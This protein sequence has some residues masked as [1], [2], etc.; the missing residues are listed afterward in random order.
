MGDDTMVK[1]RAQDKT[2]QWRAAGMMRSSPVAGNAMT[3]RG[4]AIVIMSSCDLRV[5]VQQRNA[6]RHVVAAGG[7]EGVGCEG[8]GSEGS[9]SAALA[10]D[11]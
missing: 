10:L 4:G 5:Q 11:A 1:N 2:G 7:C 6:V 8:V 9:C 3:S